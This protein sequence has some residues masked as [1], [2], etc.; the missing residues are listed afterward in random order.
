MM[1][2]SLSWIKL[3][4]P[5][6]FSGEQQGKSEHLHT[7]GE[8]QVKL[9]GLILL[10]LEFFSE[11]EQSPAPRLVAIRPGNSGIFHVNGSANCVTFLQ[12]R[13]AKLLVPGISVEV[14]FVVQSQ[15]GTVNQDSFAP[16]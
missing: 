8:L 1:T 10:G 7:K 16:A 6:P 9:E 5:A 14:V 11:D 15:I 3:K 2:P 4:S 12:Q 13:W